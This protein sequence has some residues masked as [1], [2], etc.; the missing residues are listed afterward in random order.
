[1]AKNKELKFDEI[2]YW[3]EIKLDII[4]EYAQAYTKILSS[5]PQPF[6]YSYIDAF[7][8]TGRHI[9]KKT[10][11]TVSGSPLNALQLDPAFKEYH[12]I[13]MNSLK[14]DEL[15]KYANEHGNVNVYEGDCN[16][17]LLDQ[18]FPQLRWENYKRALCLLDPYGL[19][20]KWDVLKEAAKMKTIEIFFNF[21]IMDAN[22]NVLWNQPDKVTDEQI[23][24]MDACWG[25]NSWNDIA[26]DT[27]QNL[28]GWKEKTDN[29]TIAS[30]FRD[31]LENIA[32][33]GYVPEP[34]PMRNTNGAIVY[35]LFFAAHRP[36][37]SKIVKS[38]F[39]KYCSMGEK[40]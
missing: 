36:V 14:V 26:Y 30:A 6:H 1:M 16:K 10:G 31:R 28:F 40:K 12:F 15:K 29:Q 2:G 13:D 25:D 22:M 7:A 5:Q 9:S 23:S 18:I 4:R 27:S 33:F 8:G 34:I 3:S 39:K 24:R 20:L 38:I 32:G 21:S 11:E 17:I 35:Y 37:S 19:H